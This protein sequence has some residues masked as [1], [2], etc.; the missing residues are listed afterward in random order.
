M[1]GGKL[2]TRDF[3]IITLGTVISM[4]GNAVSGFAISLLVLDYTGSVFLYSV[5]LV[6]YN[7]PKIIAPMV[8]GPL[9]DRLS[10]RRAIY[11]LDFCSAAL[12]T[13]IFLF[14]LLDFF[15][16]PLFA[17]MA[18]VIG[19]I[20][21]TYTTAYDSLYPTL[22]TPGNFEKAYSVSSMIQPL[23]A[24][25][26]P[27]AAFLY[28]RVGLQPLFL[29]NAASFL[30]AA[31]FETQIRG[32]GEGHPSTRQTLTQFRAD[33][34]EGLRYVK[35]QPGLR[36]LTGYFAFN[37]FC[38][39]VFTTIFMPYFKETPGLGVVLYTLVAGCG[40]VGRVAGSAVQY[41]LRL[42]AGRKAE[43]LLLFCA[44]LCVTDGAFLFLPLWGMM[45][46]Q[47]CSGL[48]N[49]GIYNLRVSGTQSYLPDDRRG[50]FNGTFLTLTTLGSIL[51]QLLSGALADLF[52]GRAVVAGAMALNLIGVGVLA[53]RRRALSPVME[54]ES[55]APPE[56][57]PGAG[58]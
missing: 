34:R 7:L 13:G 26:V 5:F 55:A 39:A 36:T 56:E 50:R 57:T 12:Y 11:L 8:S 24:V 27:V 1:S 22:I 41:R 14:L 28:E 54:A 2:W 46:L 37:M 15:S 29:F 6:I 42:P 30:I 16:F 48:L 18:F 40:V 43:L 17:A 38:S 4:L 44:L 49:A 31:V 32:G 23:A 9:L 53:R 33:L 52:S 58:K 35:G 20:D 10:R 25:M 51:G 45:V 3:T 19:A 47:F 21:G